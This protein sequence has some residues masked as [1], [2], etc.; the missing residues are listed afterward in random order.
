MFTVIL[1]ADMLSDENAAIRK[2]RSLQ[3]AHPVVVAHSLSM[4]TGR[5]STDKEKNTGMAMGLTVV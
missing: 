1:C 2:G 4:E 3:L 5:R